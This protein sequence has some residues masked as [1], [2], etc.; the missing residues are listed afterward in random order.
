MSLKQLL[1]SSD[2]KFVYHF[3]PRSAVSSLKY[4]LQEYIDGMGVVPKDKVE[5]HNSPLHR[6]AA[7]VAR[8]V[9]E[10]GNFPE[11]FKFVV[12]RNPYDRVLSFYYEYVLTGTSHF[13]K[14]VNTF[15]L[16]IETLKNVDRLNLWGPEHDHIM[17]TINMLAPLDTYDKIYKLEE[18]AFARIT[19]DLGLDE[20]EKVRFSDADRL[21][22]YHDLDPKQADDLFE[23]IETIY[24]G[25]LDTFKYTR[26]ESNYLKRMRYV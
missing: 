9:A 3:I 25:D 16:F 6:N 8:E 5:V 1:V 12:V 10:L 18:D 15:E 11:H 21:D 19:K 26:E 4:N 2:K 7:A 23:V 13:G 14:H 22:T 24:S 20:F 17:P